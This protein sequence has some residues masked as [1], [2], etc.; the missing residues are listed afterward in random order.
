VL[1]GRVRG[2]RMRIDSGG[3]PTFHSAPGSKALALIAV[4]SRRL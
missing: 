2:A 1:V 3:A 4:V